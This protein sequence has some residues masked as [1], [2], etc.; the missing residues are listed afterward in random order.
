ALHFPTATERDG[1]ARLDTTFRERGHVVPPPWV[2]N[3]PVEKAERA[4]GN[5]VLFLS[6]LH[7][8]KRVECLLD[9]WPR[10]RADH[11][12]ARLVIAGDGEERYIRSLMDRTRL[13]GCCDS[14]EFIGF[15]SSG[16]KA[17]LL[18]AASVFVL[19]SRHENF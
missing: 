9:A 19:P 14:V 10:V 7:P 12:S 17:R 11:P 4:S 5:M 6:R 15:A 8:V 16:R 1:A 18:S 2:A 13:N 3:L